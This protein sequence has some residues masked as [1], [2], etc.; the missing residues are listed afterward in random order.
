MPGSR[1]LL[2]LVLP[3]TL[4]LMC[5]F[6]GIAYWVSAP[7]TVVIG[8][9]DDGSNESS[10]LRAFATQ[11]RAERHAF[12]AKIK[13]ARTHDELRDALRKGETDVAALTSSDLIPDNLETLAVL[14]RM[15]L[16]MLTFGA[17]VSGRKSGPST[18]ALVAETP[19]DE[20]HGRIILNALETDE[21]AAIELMSAQDAAKAMLTGRI[22]FV[23]FASSSPANS[24]RQF[25]AAMPANQ[26]EGLKLLPMPR[27]EQL[28]R[29]STGIEPTAAKVGS[30]WSVPLLPDEEIEVPSV[31]TRLIARTAMPDH[32]AGHVTRA[33][34][35]MQRR[36]ASTLPA[37]S[38]IEPPPVERGSVLPTHAGALAYLN[39]NESTFIDRFGDWIYLGLFGASAFGSI[40]A[41]FVSWQNTMQRWADVKRLKT[42][43]GLI[44]ESRAAM[45]IAQLDMAHERYQRLMDDVVAAAT[46]LEINQTDFLAFMIANSVYLGI[47]SARSAE[48]TAPLSHQPR[49]TGSMTT[50]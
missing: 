32:V 21:G 46:R 18:T 15:R 7:S 16:H 33:I 37:A 23:A 5:A 49:V 22:S 14:G 20:R 9:V 12:V 31:T 42:L 44:S 17:S 34:L 45:T 40:F 1:H 4:A 13:S 10:I 6:I 35:S 11:I 24:M 43:H 26:R 50:A 28:Q 2:S 29:Q 30:V 25:M 41:G 27:P 38:Q 3:I 48:L 47:Y 36:L 8:V 39:G 19:L